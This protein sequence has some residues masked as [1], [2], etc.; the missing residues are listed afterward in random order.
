MKTRL[1]LTAVFGPYGVKNKYAEAL[2]MQMEL[3]NNQITRTQG[4]HSP[5]QAYWTFPLYFLAENISVETTVLDFPSWS[6]FTREL[7][8]GYTHVGINFIIPNA[9][10]AQRMARYIRKHHPATIIILGGYGTSIPDLQSVVPHDEVCREE[11]IRWLRKYFNENPD[12]PLRHPV[13][14]GPAYEYLYGARGKPR[15]AILMP[16][17]GC[18]NACKFCA[19]SHQF[20]KTYLPLLPGGEDIFRACCDIEAKIDSRGFTI[21]DE[22]F[23]K[24]P[25]RAREL[26][27]FMTTNNKPFVFDIFSSAEVIKKMGVDFLVRLGVRMIWVGVESKNSEFDK[28]RGIDLKE[29]FRELKSHGIVVQAST[30]LFQDHHD[31]QTITKDIDY[32]IGLGTDFI[33]FMNYTP[34]PGTTLYREM[35]EKGRLK[36]LN[37]RYVHGAGELF[38]THP[39][40]NDRNI[41]ARY[42]RYA[43]RKSYTVDGPGV[44]SMAETIFMG[45]RKALADY[46]HRRR[47][48][49]G[50]DPLQNSY[51]VMDGPVDDQFMKIRLRMMKRLA[52][53]IRIILPA[54]FVFAPNMKARKKTLRIAKLAFEALGKPTLKQKLLSAVLIVTGTV[55]LVRIQFN[56]LRGREGVV[57]QPARKITTYNNNRARAHD[58]EMKSLCYSAVDSVE[59]RAQF[60]ER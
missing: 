8:R 6:D 40:I 2:G 17:V 11:G 38:Q 26:L 30:M 34:L 9:L 42:L 10:K 53:N 22:N 47:N 56:R 39:H 55:E 13:I 33:Q 60:N 57:H 44:V 4:V 52:E 50:W 15:G 3:M 45:Y 28:T 27:A 25:Q 58:R 46:E 23:L 1:L 18:E 16:G 24:S 12:A 21:L 41:L 37:F 35:E 32:V 31:D 14:H 43:G 20:G 54:A 29:L 36:Y 51:A 48:N 59:T 49:I 5:R 7:A 19:T